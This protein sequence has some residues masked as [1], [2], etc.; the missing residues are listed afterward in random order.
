LGNTKREVK[1]IQ[2]R[3]KRAM[4]SLHLLQLHLSGPQNCVSQVKEDPIAADGVQP[5]GRPAGRKKEKERQRQHSDQSKID[6]LDLLWNKKKEV[7]AEKDR[8]REERYRAA[9]A[10]EQK[11]IDLDKEKLDFKR[12]IQEDRIVRLDTSAMSIE[13]Q[14]YYKSVKSSI[15]SRRS[16]ST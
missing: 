8:Q 11:R 16:A 5:S 14:E 1:K 15:L 2:V 6:A 3:N 7:D 10:L 9:L 13:E 12:M 4:H